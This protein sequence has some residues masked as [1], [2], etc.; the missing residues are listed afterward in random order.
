MK[1]KDFPMP[2]YFPVSGIPD[3]F[4]SS[5][6]PTTYV[7]SKEGKIIYKHGGMANYSKK[8]FREWLIKQA[9]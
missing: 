7:V 2:Y 6:I 4:Q 5:Y 3:V 8:H 1:G 9:K